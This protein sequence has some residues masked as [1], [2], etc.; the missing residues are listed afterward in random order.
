VPSCPIVTIGIAALKGSRPD[1]I[2]RQYGR[3]RSPVSGIPI[4]SEPVFETDYDASLLS[5]INPKTIHLTPIT[6]DPLANT[7]ADSAYN[8]LVLLNKQINK[9]LKNHF[10]VA[11]R[12]QTDLYVQYPHG[13]HLLHTTA[14]Q[15]LHRS[16]TVHIAGTYT[17]RE[18]C[19]RRGARL[20]QHACKPAN[21]VLQGDVV[22]N[23]AKE[24][25]LLVR[26]MFDPSQQAFDRL[27]MRIYFPGAN[28]YSTIWSDDDSPIVVALG[29][30]GA[31]RIELETQR[32][33]L[34]NFVILTAYPTKKRRDVT[35][36]S[37]PLEEGGH[38]R[39]KEGTCVVN[40]DWPSSSAKDYS[41]ASATLKLG[42]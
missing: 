35:S 19:P 28:S 39:P 2:Y 15:L 40:P 38:G 37:R 4:D 13:L 33:R 8:S 12:R 10:A 3:G 23:A 17:P 29:N 7:Q 31:D 20:P 5:A 22:P 16:R 27:E 32:G 18:F 25:G 42:I 30:I 9:E 6:L 41:H 34:G 21:E 24:L 11:T 1:I 14:P 26:T 36:R